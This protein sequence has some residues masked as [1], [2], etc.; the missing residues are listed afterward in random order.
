MDRV[1]QELSAFDA[2]AVGGLDESR[3]AFWPLDHQTCWRNGQLLQE[4]DLVAAPRVVV[5]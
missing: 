1:V 4:T 2:Q 5:T 3:L